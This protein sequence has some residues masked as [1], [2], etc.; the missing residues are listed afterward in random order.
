MMPTTTDTSTR[1]LTRASAGRCRDCP[2]ERVCA[3]SCVQGANM[4]DIIT[5]AALFVEGAATVTDAGVALTRD[6]LIRQALWDCYN[7][8]YQM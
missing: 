7:A 1:L 3:W 4:A 6:D 8:S 2:P 5:G